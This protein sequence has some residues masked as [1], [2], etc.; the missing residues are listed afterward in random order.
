MA[1]LIIEH[2]DTVTDNEAIMA[3]Y[4]VVEHG[5]VSKAKHG[6]H[7]CW[8]TSWENGLQVVVRVK[9]HPNAADSFIV[10]RQ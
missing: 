9:R 1:K 6:E 2:D 7:Y 5:R 3:V 10:W 8:H 4:L